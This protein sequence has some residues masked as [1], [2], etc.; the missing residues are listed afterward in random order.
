[1]RKVFF[2]FSILI[3]FTYIFSFSFDSKFIENRGQY[4]SEI[5]YY[6]STKDG[7]MFFGDNSFGFITSKKGYTYTYRVHLD[8]KLT[9]GEK[10]ITKV[11][12]YKGNL[13]LT[14]LKTYKTLFYK[15]K[16]Y[17]IKFYKNNGRVEWDIKTEDIKSVKL[18]Y[19]IG[20]GEIEAKGNRL[21][22]KWQ[23]GEILEM[24]PK[25]ICEGKEVKV[26]YNIIGKNVVTFKSKDLNLNGGNTK[27]TIDPSTFLGGDGNDECKTI[28]VV[29]E[30][31]LVVGGTTTDYSSFPGSSSKIGEVKSTIGE[32]DIF[33]ARTGFNLK[34]LD[35]I[36]FIGS[37]ENDDINSMK[38]VGN[39]IFICGATDDPETFMPDYISNA[40]GNIHSFDDTT[41]FLITLSLDPF[42]IKPNLSLLIGGTKEDVCNDISIVSLQSVYVC[43]E[44]ESINILPAGVT[45]Y[46]PSWFHNG[47]TYQDKTGF[48]MKIKFNSNGPEIENGTYVGG[49][50]SD[51][52]EVCYG[53]CVKRN[54]DLTVKSV[55]ICGY[56]ETNE[57]PS[58][59]NPPS[60]IGGDSAAYFSKLS[61]DLSSFLG[62]V[63]FDGSGDDVAKR[64]VYEPDGDTLF[65]GG[66]TNS[67]D[68]LPTCVGGTA[69]CAENW[70]NLNGGDDCFI[71][72]TEAKNL[73][74]ESL[75]GIPLG[76]NNDDELY[77]LTLY[78]LEQTSDVHLFIEGQFNGKA[79]VKYVN[80]YYD[81][82]PDGSRF[83][84]RKESEKD[85]YFTDGVAYDATVYADDIFIA[86]TTTSQNY[87][88]T[89]PVLD[90]DFSGNSEGFVASLDTDTLSVIPQRSSR[91]IVTYPASSSTQIPTQNLNPNGEDFTLNFRAMKFTIPLD[92]T[93]LSNLTPHDGVNFSIKLYDQDGHPLK[94]ATTQSNITENDWTDLALLYPCN[95]CQISPET[96]KIV[97]WV[98]NDNEIK[99]NFNTDINP[100]CENLPPYWSFI[101]FIPNDQW[102]HTDYLDNNNLCTN[103]GSDQYQDTTMCIVKNFHTDAS[104]DTGYIY[105]KFSSEDN[106]I[107]FETP[108]G[109]EI[110]PDY[111]MKLLDY[112]FQTDTESVSTKVD[113]VAPA[114]KKMVIADVGRVV[115]MP[116]TGELKVKKGRKK[117]FI[118]ISSRRKSIFIFF[119][120]GEGKFFK[121]KFPTGTPISLACADLDKD[122]ISEIIVGFADGS[123][124]IYTPSN[125]L[126]KESGDL[127][128]LRKIFEIKTNGEP[129]DLKS[130][131]INNDGKY[132][133]I[134][135][136]DSNDSVVVLY[137]EDYTEEKEYYLDGVPEKMTIAD[138]NG[139]GL[140]DICIAKSSGNSVSI[141][142]NSGD[143]S[144]QLNEVSPGGYQFDY[145]DIDHG[146]FNRDGIYDIALSSE[147]EQAIVSAI[148]T[149]G[150][151]I[152]NNGVG[153]SYTPS[154]IAVSNLDAVNGDDVLVG[155][156]DYYKLILCSSDE[157]GKIHQRF[158]INTLDDIEIDPDNGVILPEDDVAVIIDGLSYGGV[159][160]MTGMV[161]VVN[162]KY[163]LF[164]FPKSSNISFSLINVDDDESLLMNFELYDKSGA[165]LNFDT[166]SVS[167]HSQ[168]AGYFSSDDIFGDD[169][170]DDKFVRLFITKP[171]PYGIYLF[172]SPTNPNTLDG[173]KLISAAEVKTNGV[174]PVVKTE[175]GYTKIYLINPFKEENELKISLKSKD[176]VEK[177]SKDVTLNSREEKVYDLKELFNTIEDEDYVE[178]FSNKGFLG[179][180]SFGTDETLGIL[181]SI[182]PKT[183]DSVLY[184]PHIASGTFGDVVY[185]TKIDLIN[186]SN[187][188]AIVNIYLYSDDGSEVGKVSDYTLKAHEKLESSLKDL[189]NLDESVG[190]TGYLEVES[191]EDSALVGSFT[192]EN[193][194]GTILSSLP[195]TSEKGNLIMPHIANGD[196]GGI[197]YWTGLAILSPDSDENVSIKVYDKDGKLIAEKDISLKAGQRFVS[198]LNGDDLFPNIGNVMGGWIT[199]EGD[200]K[201]LMAVELF[202]DRDFS[203]MSVVPATKIPE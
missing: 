190:T 57:L 152:F 80:G 184:C 114:F 48:V 202:G 182:Y 98:K 91:I 65:I 127:G 7:V 24:I 185:E 188:D 27:I 88:I 59:P 72:T 113:K 73:A 155:F 140:E 37:N 50:S 49:E 125:I 62:T 177:D 3:F 97:K 148:G 162:Q 9:T 84:F 63:Y 74:P 22:L 108:D 145:E 180:E 156:S 77:N 109:S 79:G 115:V 39:F 141:L 116:D 200:N 144:Y 83:V 26:S 183:G 2:I 175:D 187:D 139:D 179:I 151:I 198:T 159:S 18:K 19:E 128:F 189:F 14:N 130:M 61:P 196:I 103:F 118:S 35:E 76:T 36:T 173:G 161:G 137:G 164:Y 67:N 78:T 192:F 160:D 171:Y 135:L 41:G 70:Q 64:I 132:D 117:D 134:Y 111:H 138:V 25:S 153:I 75:N 23:N 146:D 42:E 178:I 4:P 172:N 52:D 167:S 86:G 123:I 100:D 129:K 99:I 191:S 17:K 38:N 44:T 30:D 165:L 51:D 32:K 66:T 197:N 169:A 94:F 29:K 58:C 170:G 131:D 176:G 5:K 40:Y 166:L 147:G 186:V 11:N 47:T 201:D 195:F 95:P 34:V 133:L 120:E 16:D 102:P 13:K 28:K 112:N 54:S 101:L 45:G 142:Y 124:K 92:E 93:N 203:I 157:D 68:L 55:F 71:A 21:Y 106:Y 96:G 107:T 136:D 10:N 193:S 199:I 149:P 158:V 82:I 105:A 126:N 87:P 89:P 8:G 143:G 154:A 81:S 69:P 6:T 181:P 104:N 85:H 121:Y 60:D 53:I 46:A 122:G 174:F 119:R 12:I 20:N 43:G 1:M 194:K 110:T 163:N 31:Y 90:K 150:G 33:L 15:S 56:T 168:Y